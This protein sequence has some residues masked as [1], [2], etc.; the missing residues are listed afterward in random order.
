MLEVSLICGM[1]LDGI[2]FQQRHAFLQ[3]GHFFVVVCHTYTG[4]V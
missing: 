3:K 2:V 1:W 4:T